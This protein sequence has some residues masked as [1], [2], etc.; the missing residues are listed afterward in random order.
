MIP[1][2]CL[3]PPSAAPRS[4]RS[5]GVR[6][7]RSLTGSLRSPAARTGGPVTRLSASFARLITRGSAIIVTSVTPSSYGS[8]SDLFRGP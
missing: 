3:L 7:L 2:R 5:L 1:G 6:S 4:L 8:A